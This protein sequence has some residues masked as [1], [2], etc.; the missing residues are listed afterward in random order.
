MGYRNARLQFTI[1]FFNL[2]TLWSDVAWGFGFVQY[3]LEQENVFYDELCRDEDQILNCTI[4]CENNSTCVDQCDEPFICESAKSQYNF[5]YTVFQ[6][7]STV[8]G[9]CFEPILQKFGFL[10]TR[11]RFKNFWKFED[12]RQKS[13]IAVRMWG[14]SIFWIFGRLI[15]FTLTT[16]GATLLVFYQSNADLVTYGWIILGLPKF[17]YFVTNVNE[18]RFQNFSPTCQL[19]KDARKIFE[20]NSSKR[21]DFQIWHMVLWL[22]S[23]VSLI[24]LVEFLSLLKWFTIPV[25]ASGWFSNVK[26]PDNRIFERS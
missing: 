11:K 8:V 14:S 17:G 16:V 23:V 1:T 22:L 4:N 12:L 21:I 6:V 20:N 9:V 10:V 7:T 5:I 3:C 26:L 25:L 18:D 15:M 19:C 24:F 2:S 13:W